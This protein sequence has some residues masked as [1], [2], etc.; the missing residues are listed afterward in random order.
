MEASIEVFGTIG[1]MER[2]N[3]Q[4]KTDPI[5]LQES[6]SIMGYDRVKIEKN[7]GA[8]KERYFSHL[9]E[10]IRKY[11][12]ELKPGVVELLELVDEDENFLCGLLTGNFKESATIKLSSHGLN[13]FFKFGVYG[14]DGQTRNDLPPVARKRLMDELG[15]DVDYSD[16]VIIGDTVYDIEC[17]RVVGAVSI[18]VGTG[19]AEKDILLEKEPDYYFDDLSDTAAVMD[20]IQNGK[21]SIIQR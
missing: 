11:E 18:A 15:M 6:L 1:R 12:V 21:P 14:D 16:M 5:I 7:I 9:K 17:A 8:L 3:F 10:N 2:V 13:R 4:G 20:I 19:W